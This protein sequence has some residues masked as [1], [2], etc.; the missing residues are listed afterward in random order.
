[1][2]A[3][4]AKQ[5]KLAGHIA[6]FY[7]NSTDKVGAENQ[8][9]SYFVSRLELLESYWEKFTNNHDQLVC[10]EK[11]FASHQYFAEDG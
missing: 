3:L 2:E 9:E 10:Y 4:L 6:N 11:E 1:M 8:T 7:T 5:L